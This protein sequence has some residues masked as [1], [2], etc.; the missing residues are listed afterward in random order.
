MV[1]A[2]HASPRIVEQRRHKGDAC[3]APTVDDFEIAE[4]QKM[5]RFAKTLDTDGALCISACYAQ[6]NCCLA[7]AHACAGVL[8]VGAEVGAVEAVALSVRSAG[9]AVDAVSQTVCARE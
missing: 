1:G 7:G 5:Y 4:G 2:R 6:R 3:I 9:E 8:S